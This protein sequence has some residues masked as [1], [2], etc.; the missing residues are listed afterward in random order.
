MSDG[1]VEKSSSGDASPTER[2]ISRRSS[3]ELGM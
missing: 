1:M 2:S 3:G